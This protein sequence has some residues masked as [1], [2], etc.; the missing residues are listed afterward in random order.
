MSSSARALE[1]ERVARDWRWLIVTAV[2]VCGAG[3]LFAA[4]FTA[5]GSDNPDELGWDFRVAY[6]PAAEA[7]VEGRSPYPADPSDPRLD[8]P[9][10]Y[11][12]PP[13]LAM[14]LAPLTALPVD[15]AVVVAVIASALALIGSLAIVGVRDIRCFAALFI[16]APAWNALEMANVSALL[17]LLL[18]IAWRYR[19]TT[20]P[21]AAVLGAAVS[22]KLF[23]WPILVW[24][25]MCRRARTAL[26]AVALGTVLT[27]LA[28]AVIGFAGVSSYGEVLDRVATQDSYSIKGMSE[29]LGFGQTLSYGLTL[30]VAG[31]LLA[32]SVRYARGGDEAFALLLAVLA[33]LAFSPIVWLHYL[34]LLA[35]PLGVLR[36][37]FSAIWLLPIVLWPLARSGNGE[38]IEPFVP[39][40]VVLA[41]ALVL[42]SSQRSTSGSQDARFS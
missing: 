14:L 36:P 17:A 20:W 40:L 27:A 41:M 4:L 22:L 42:L 5:F 31:A 37:H 33:A 21:L 32:M 15:A 1:R 10:L 16:W 26:L 19:A 9:R 28:W 35:V 23:L 12:Y 34:V 30:I 29:T 39:A 24:A 7:V 8:G 3:V 38:G 13:Q 25:G 2:L 11:V 6:Y 18:A